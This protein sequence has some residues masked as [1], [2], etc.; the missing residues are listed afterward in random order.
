MNIQDVKML[1]SKGEGESI[2]FKRKVVHPEK[3]IR[4]IVAFANTK[5]GYLL[6]GVDDDGSIPGLKFADE[7][8]FALEQAIKK[9]CRPEINYTIETIPFSRKKSVVSFRVKESS[10]KPHYVLGNCFHPHVS[11]TNT[12][13]VGSKQ[14]ALN[15]TGIE[16][17]T[18]PLNRAYVRVKD[19]SLQASR[20]VWEVLRRTR[21]P[22]DIKFSFGDKEKILMEFLHEKESITLKE[23]KKIARLSYF[24]ASRTLVLLV[25]ANVLEIVPQE[26]EDIFKLRHIQ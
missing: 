8:V 6:V 25:L 2:E 15:G 22:K 4:E 5:G 7:N 9:W 23:F 11:I 14:V 12:L 3:I 24:R 1:V 18:K 13:P 20:E 19:K 17:K 26:K 16:K 10:Q 21:K